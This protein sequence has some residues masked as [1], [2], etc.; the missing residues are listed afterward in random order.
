MTDTSLE[1]TDLVHTRLIAKSG[2]ERF[3]MH[4]VVSHWHQRV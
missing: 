1:I 3:L 2:A 4:S